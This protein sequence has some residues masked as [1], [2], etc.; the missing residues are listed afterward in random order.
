MTTEVLQTKDFSN[1]RL[2][3][4]E[5]FIKDGLNCCQSVIMAFKDVL[6]S[7][8]DGCFDYLI[9][10]TAGMG[11]GMGN[12]RGTCGTVSAMGLLMGALTA[13]KNPKKSANVCYS[14]FLFVAFLIYIS[15][16]DWSL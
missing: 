14:K 7:K 8:D 9:S 10:L 6:E 13:D 16:T 11:S 5:A 4:E 12:L 1:R 2:R 15:L 3:A